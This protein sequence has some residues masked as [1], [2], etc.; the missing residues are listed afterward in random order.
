MSQ[1]TL[2]RIANVLEKQFDGRIDMAD[3]DG[4][5]E[6]DRRKAFLSR[7]VAAL[8]IKNLAEVDFDIA[9]KSVTDGFHDNGIDAVHFDQKNDTV[10]IVQSKW[11]EDGTKPL[12][13]DGSG[14]L[15]TGVRDLLAAKFD[16]FNPKVRAKEAEVTA[17]L[18]SERPIKFLIVTAHTATQPLSPHVSRKIDDLVEELNDTLPIANSV[19]FDQAGIYNLITSESR[20]PKIKLQIGLKDWGVI[21][22]PFLAYYGRVHVNDI[23]QWWSE[24]RNALFT[25]NLRLYYFNSDVNDALS[26]TLANDPENFWYFNNGITV[27]CDSLSKAAVGSPGRVLGL[28]TCTG[29]NIVNGAQTVGT[30]GNSGG[31]LAATSDSEAEESWVQVRIISLEKCPPDFARAITRAANLQNAVGNRE[32]A[33]MDPVQH[34]LATDFALDKRRYVYKQGESDPKGDGGCDIVEA[35]Q[36]LACSYSTALTVQVKR[37]I[38]AIWADTNRSPYTDIFNENL[39]STAVWRAVLIMRIVDKELQKLRQSNV[40]SADLIAVHL[41]RLILHLVFQ[42]VSL[43]SLRHDNADE[44]ACL[45]AASEATQKVFPRVAAYIESEHKDNYLASFSKNLTRCATLAKVLLGVSDPNNGR[46][47]GTLFD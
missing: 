38:G 16:R 43:K 41:N 46:P 24:H 31:V 18:Y 12:D 26:R 2:T 27:I 14:T 47:Q 25:Q 32:F 28:F 22:K 8:C 45:T 17:A 4:R 10:V 1:H 3:W 19:N 7:A 42:D 30:I 34:R 39:T 23:L 5:P 37:E 20:P 21:E 11:S 33:A 15:V 6:A 36:A 13:A 9:A 29:A 44:S 35:T 40:F